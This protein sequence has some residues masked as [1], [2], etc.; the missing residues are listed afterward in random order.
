MLWLD[1]GDEAA[2]LASWPVWA[3][4]LAI[5]RDDSDDSACRSAVTAKIV[6]SNIADV[7]A[8]A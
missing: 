6:A 8:L 4:R 5:G 7:V 2:R 1:Q 3:D